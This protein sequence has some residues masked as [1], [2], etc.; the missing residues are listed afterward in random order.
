MKLADYRNHKGEPLYVI[1]FPGTGRAMFQDMIDSNLER[2]FTVSNDISIISIMNQSCLSDSPLKKQ[3][4]YNNIRLY[5][6]A[7]DEYTWNNTLKINHIL[8][9]L[10]QI[11]THYAL[12]LDGRDVIITH[13]LD[14]SFI[15]KFKCFGK[16]IVYNGTP[17]A[18]PHVAIEPLQEILQVR[19][20]QKF[21]NAGVCIGEVDALKQF[22][23]ECK[24]ISDNMIDNQS[25]QLVVR[26]ARQNMKNLIAI[27][28]DNQMLRICH[29]YDTVIKEE[30]DK[31]I[32]I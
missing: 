4:D 24:H 1:H 2:S 16:P 30:D 10:D 21:L 19:G 26:L 28:H 20:K 17:T 14:D 13:N 23:A 12:L 32:L 29:S 25:E 22:Y 15:T 8:T 27:D 31:V 9:C 5:N 7:E 11:S 6:T 3:C 18:F